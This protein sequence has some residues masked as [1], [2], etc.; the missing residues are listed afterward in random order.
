MPLPEEEEPAATEPGPAEAETPTIP[1][2]DPLDLFAEAPGYTDHEL[3]WEHEIERHRDATGLFDAIRES[4]HAGRGDG[5]TRDLM[6]A[7]REAHM[8]TMIR[9]AIKEKHERIAVVC[10]AWHS[11]V[12]VDHGTAKEDAALLKGLAKSKVEST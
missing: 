3:W 12:L 7:R 5:A 8:R 1:N 4:M 6:E 11:P 2:R 10:G 9:A